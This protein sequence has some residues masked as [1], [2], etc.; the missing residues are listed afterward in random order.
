MNIKLQR[1]RVEY[2]AISR[3]CAMRAAPQCPNG[4]TSRFVRAI[5]AKFPGNFARISAES[6]DRSRP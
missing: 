4:A 2:P 3:R 5:S 6:P 1:L